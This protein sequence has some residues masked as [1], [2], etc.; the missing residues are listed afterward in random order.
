MEGRPVLDE[1]SRSSPRT[2]MKRTEKRI[3]LHEKR[4]QGMSH[5]NRLNFT[6]FFSSGSVKTIILEHLLCFVF[7][8]DIR[9]EIDD[10]NKKHFEQHITWLQ[11]KRDSE[12]SKQIEK[13]L[14]ALKQRREF[15][16]SPLMLE[17]CNEAIEK[18]KRHLQRL[19][20]IQKF[21]DEMRMDF[22]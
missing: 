1:Q 20:S 18:D 5:S 12:T 6:I 3:K 19:K 21:E 4:A 13:E 8:L 16:K 15:L 9:K 2:R 10:V 17:G 14:S 22:T 11:T 7:D